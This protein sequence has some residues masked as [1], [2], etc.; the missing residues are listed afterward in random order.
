MLQAIAVWQLMD[1]RLIGEGL[2]H[3]DA[4]VPQKRDGGHLGVP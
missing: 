4:E 1:T 2:V 3:E